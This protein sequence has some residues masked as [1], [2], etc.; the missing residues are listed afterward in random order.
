MRKLAHR[1]IPTNRLLVRT[2]VV[3]LGSHMK[4]LAPNDRLHL[5]AADCWISL[6]DLEQAKVELTEVSPAFGDHPDVLQVCW[7]IA[8]KAGEWDRCVAIATK[9]T[10]TTPEHG[11]GWVHLD[12]SLRHL[13]RIG[14]A[15]RVLRQ[16]IEQCGEAPTFE[17]SLACCHARLGS[18]SRARKCVKRALELVKEPQ[19]R[20]RL[21][22]RALDEADLEAVWRADQASLAGTNKSPAT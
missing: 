10:Q 13:D 17:L 15:I 3:P 8:A 11:F 2:T 14:E 6:G 22:L 7:H 16:G 20:N 1:W 9:L 12:L 4:H 21:L 19:A 18:L 5:N